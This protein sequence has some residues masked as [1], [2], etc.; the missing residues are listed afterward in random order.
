MAMKVTIIG[1]GN[2][3]G[4]IACGIARGETIKAEDIT[5]VD[6]NPDVLEKMRQTGFPFILTTELR[7]AIP[8]ADILIL[9]VKPYMAEEVIAEFRDLIDYHN[10]IL[11]SVVAGVSFE[12]L[13]AYLFQGAKNIRPIQFRVMPN[14]AISIKESMTFIAE[15]NATKAQIRLVETLF[16]EMGKTM[17]IPE[18]LMD[19]AMAMGSCG[20]AYV[21][22]FVRA[23]MMGGVEMGFPPAQSLE[24]V[25]Q[26]CKG[27][28][29]LLESKGSHPEEEIDRV[30]TPGGFTI[31]GLNEM[32][33]HGF[34][35]AVISGIRV[36]S[37]K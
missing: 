14:T 8:D 25:L 15:Q 12:Q 19:Q 3:G 9:A 13:E 31:R 21:M 37:K 33:K 23:A 5:C 28:L 16:S 7:R 10:Q 26:T 36:S 2:M 20:V 24:I 34:T 32:E 18:R 1:A 35:D 11:F 6:P 30:T 4:A 22:R 29:G 17:I 27:A